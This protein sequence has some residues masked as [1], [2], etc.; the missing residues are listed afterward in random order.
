MFCRYRCRSSAAAALLCLAALSILAIVINQPTYAR[1]SAQPVCAAG[2]PDEFEARLSGGGTG[3]GRIA[4]SADPSEEQSGYAPSDVELGPGVGRSVKS[5]RKC[6]TISLLVRRV[7]R[8][9][10]I[11]L[12]V[13]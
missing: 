7:V 11:E 5:Q 6:V 12:D 8:F 1:T 9:L 3:G 10:A 4:M 13:M 2:D